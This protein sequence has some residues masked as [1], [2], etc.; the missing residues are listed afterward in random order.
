MPYTAATDS[1]TKITFQTQS[2]HLLSLRLSSYNNNNNS[3]LSLFTHSFG[4]FFTVC[5]E[6]NLKTNMLMLNNDLLPTRR[7]YVLEPET[8]RTAHFFSIL[9]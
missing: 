3:T 5:S 8:V 6:R 7:V 2:N 9:S 1:V 4:S